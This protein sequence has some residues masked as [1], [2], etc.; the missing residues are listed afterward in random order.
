M[1]VVMIRK[2]SSIS[3]WHD[4][5]Q[6]IRALF[7]REP[8]KMEAIAEKEI[9]ITDEELKEF[10]SDFFS[11]SE[12]IKANQELMKVDENG[13]W[14]CLKITSKKADYSILVNSEGC[15][16]ARYTAIIKK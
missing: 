6:S 15:D 13:I 1:K 5:V 3:G 16:Y 11:D 10:E 2:A 4:S 7:G 12:I 8:E 14:H 9:I